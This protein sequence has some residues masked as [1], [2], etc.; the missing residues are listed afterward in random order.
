[1]LLL[2]AWWHDPDDVGTASHAEQMPISQAG[3]PVLAGS[4]STTASREP[5]DAPAHVVLPPPGTPL[6]VVFDELAEA[7]DAGHTPSA[8]RL[9]WDLARCAHLPAMASLPQMLLDRAAEADGGSRDEA[10]GIA[11]LARVEDLVGQDQA[12]CA[13]LSTERREEAPHRMYQAAKLGHAPSMAR[14]ALWPPFGESLTFDDA[15][16]ALAHRRHAM[17]F[18]RKSAARGEPT[19]LWGLFITCHS[20]EIRTLHGTVEVGQDPVCALATASALRRFADPATLAEADEAIRETSLALDASDR[21]SAHAMARRYDA[22]YRDQPQ[23]DFAGGAFR[24]H[25]DDPCADIQ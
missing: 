17:D 18:L 5:R 19:G 14:F 13:G 10:A 15:D 9:A 4:S 1:M 8:C 6:A 3:P 11:R 22:I 25:L 23:Y 7:A 21:A 24:N 12:V 2:A 16:L 20:G